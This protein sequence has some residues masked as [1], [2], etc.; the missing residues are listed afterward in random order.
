MQLVGANDSYVRGP[1]IVGGIIYG[2]FSAVFALIL[3]VPTTI[4]FGE[5]TTNFFGGINI[6]DYYMSNFLEI[7]FIL[8]LSGVLLG[9]ISSVLAV[10]K[11]LR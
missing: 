3:F 4:W 6:F 8:L 1:F 11:Y 10:R 9:A 7:A 5:T 2:I